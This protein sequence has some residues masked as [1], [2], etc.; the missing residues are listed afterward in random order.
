MTPLRL[1]DL[2]SGIGGFS[3]GLER[4]GA[5]K[6]VAFCEIE[7]FPRRV[8]A[9]HWPGI[10]IHD[11]V[12]TL[13]K[14][15]LCR[16]YAQNA[17]LNQLCRET[18]GKV[19]YV[20]LA[21]TNI[22]KYLDKRTHQ[23]TTNG[24]LTVDEALLTIMAGSASAVEKQNTHFWQ[25]ITSLITETRNEEHIKSLCGSSLSN[26]DF[27]TIIKYFVITATWQ[28]RFTV[29]AHIKEI[30][31]VDSH[32]GKLERL[33]ADGIAVD[34][35]CGG[36][37]CQDISFAGLGAGLAGERS[38]L[39]FEYARL[40]GEIR[41]KYVIVENVGALFSRGLDAILGNLA[42]IGYDAEWHGIPASCVGL[43]HRRDRVWIVAYPEEE[44]CAEAGKLR[45]GKLAEWLP[46][47]GEAIVFA[48]DGEERDDRSQPQT[49]SGFPSFPWRKNGG[50]FESIG[51]RS[52][53]LDPLFRGS[54]DGVPDWMDRV[55]ALGNAVVPQIP[56]LI[57]RA[58]RS[59]LEA[60]IGI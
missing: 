3:L 26:E 45:C 2:F 50:R 33:A 11:D 52:I 16:G 55:G 1:L 36:F 53:V 47:G 15:S 10:Y 5:F 20:T 30:L 60:G 6:T 31:D 29:P 37:P 13:T 35:I 34:A 32:V 48:D 8:L 40:I 56:E 59:S 54:R 38:G 57:G 18:G 12:R 39:W 24:P 4:S 41:P 7:P 42:A 17:L 14:D 49:V 19:A 25:L 9:K 51:S 43:P 28:K 46:C 27:L 23:D 44:R 22:K 58:I 21:I